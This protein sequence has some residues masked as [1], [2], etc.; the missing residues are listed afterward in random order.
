M[1]NQLFC[2]KSLSERAPC[3][4]VLE[5]VLEVIVP[6]LVVVK[7]LTDTV[8]LSPVKC[9][10]IIIVVTLVVGLFWPLVLVVSWLPE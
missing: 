1:A 5:C 4:S 9:N 3:V 2:H 10:W 6:V 8:N 7:S